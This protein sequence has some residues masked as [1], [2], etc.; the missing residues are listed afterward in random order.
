[1][2]R[3]RQ[4]A[5][6]GRLWQAVA[7]YDR[8]RQAVAGCGRLWQAVFRVQSSEFILVKTDKLTMALIPQPS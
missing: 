6:A 5:A 1:M 7:G 4:A 2:D 8:L 3:L